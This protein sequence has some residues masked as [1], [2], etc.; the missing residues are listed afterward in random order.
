MAKHA[1]CLKPTGCGYIKYARKV[2]LLNADFSVFYKTPTTFVRY[3]KILLVLKYC[4]KKFTNKMKIHK[5]Y[6]YYHKIVL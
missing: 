3:A 4:N 2:R 5:N 6:P 1:L